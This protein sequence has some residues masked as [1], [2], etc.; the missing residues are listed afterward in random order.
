LSLF[1]MP[2]N[3]WFAGE[4]RPASMWE[5]CVW[6]MQVVS[7][8]LTM[9]LLIFMTDLR[10]E[11][12]AKWAEAV[13]DFFSAQV[14]RAAVVVRSCACSW[15]IKL[16][17][18]K[19]CLHQHGSTVLQYLTFIYLVAIF[20]SERPVCA[21]VE[22]LGTSPQAASSVTPIVVPTQQKCEGQGRTVSTEQEDRP[23]LH[24]R[25]MASVANSLEGDHDLPTIMPGRYDVLGGRSIIPARETRAARRRA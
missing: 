3:E 1:G 24:T 25:Q 22:P 12:P 7:A 20:V 17:M 5:S 15:P 10:D 13:S 2:H 16:W 9:L 11:L 4:M 8:L 18:S 21:A 14:Q 23:G 19:D 6:A